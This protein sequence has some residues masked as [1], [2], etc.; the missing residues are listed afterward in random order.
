MGRVYNSM[1]RGREIPTSHLQGRRLCLPFVCSCLFPD[2]AICQDLLRSGEGPCAI[3]QVSVPGGLRFSIPGDATQGGSPGKYVVLLDRGASWHCVG[4]SV[5]DSG[6][7]TWYD[8]ENTCEYICD[9]GE[10]P[11]MEYWDMAVVTLATES[12]LH[13]YPGMRKP[14]GG[15][16]RPCDARAKAECEWAKCGFD[17]DAPAPS[18]PQS[19]ESMALGESCILDSEYLSVPP[20]SGRVHFP[21]VDIRR[22]SECRSQGG[23]RLEIARSPKAANAVFGDGMVQGDVV[24]P[25][26]YSDPDGDDLEAEPPSIEL[27]KLILLEADSAISVAGNRTDSALV[28]KRWVKIQGSDK[29]GSS[30]EN[31]PM[32]EVVSRIAHVGAVNLLLLKAILEG[33]SRR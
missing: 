17:L 15:K 25:Y 14:L 18:S 13:M 8:S 33:Q 3:E 4:L 27:K 10:L 31:A 24:G 22:Y 6:V 29:A 23:H 16:V 2:N 20:R 19:N 30:Q 21:T 1:R 12:S 9:V 5:D 26:V 11:A 28:G 7:C 32:E